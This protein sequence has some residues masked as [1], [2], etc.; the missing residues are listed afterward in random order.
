MP[1]AG[2]NFAATQG[3]GGPT[4]AQGGIMAQPG[5]GGGV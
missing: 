5:T 3:Q 2:I 1:P 4:M